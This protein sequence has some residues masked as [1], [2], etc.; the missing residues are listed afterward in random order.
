MS[1]FKLIEVRKTS[2]KETQSIYDKASLDEAI[3]DMHNDFGVAVK[4]ED[5]L[6]A[7]CVIIDNTTGAQAK[8]LHWGEGIKDR[9]YTHNDYANDNIS[10]YDSEQLAI[11]NFHT[12]VASQRSHADCKHAITVRLGSTGNYADYDVYGVA[13]PQ[14]VQGE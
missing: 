12:K 4:Q 14:A 2:E 8:V 1:L 6:G 11:G 9:V 5:T 10:A 3:I 7:Y 13:E